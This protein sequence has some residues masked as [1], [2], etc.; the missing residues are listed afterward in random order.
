MGRSAGRSIGGAKS[1]WNPPVEAFGGGET[2]PM[3]LL[4]KKF[5]R[6]GKRGLEES[7]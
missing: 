6:C 2:L 1:G 4:R 7:G 3:L 5:L